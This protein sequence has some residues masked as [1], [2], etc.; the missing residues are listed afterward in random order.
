MSI[1]RP[2]NE[3]Q[4]YSLSPVNVSSSTSNPATAAQPLASATPSKLAVFAARQPEH[5]IN[6]FCGA[7]AGAAS[8]IV[9]CPLDVIKT[10]LQGQGGF[11]PLRRSPTSAGG[12]GPSYRG[13]FGTAET[14]WRQDGL[15]GMYRGLGPMM[16][17]YLPTW[18]V[19]MTVYGGARDY[20]Y[21]TLGTFSPPSR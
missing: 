14:I 13:L 10:K 15:R 7:V 2:N 3:K 1:N 12:A 11:R 19:Y 17:G 18:A 5:R 8:G 6:S 4:Q 20:Y 9:T 21:T 16:L